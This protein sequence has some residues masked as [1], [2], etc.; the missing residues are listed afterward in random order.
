[1]KLVIDYNFLQCV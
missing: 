1:M